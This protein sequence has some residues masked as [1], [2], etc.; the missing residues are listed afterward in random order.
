[1]DSKEFTGSINYVHVSS[2]G[3]IKCPPFG[4]SSGPLIHSKNVRMNLESSG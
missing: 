4:K 3:T 2:A 1:M